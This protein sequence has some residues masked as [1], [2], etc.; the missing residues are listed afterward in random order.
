MPTPNTYVGIDPGLTGAVVV[1]RGNDIIGCFDA[2]V[3]VIKKG[4][5]K[6]TELLPYDMAAR[7]LL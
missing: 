7:R 2:P 6:K 3:E 1:I 5:K 4:G